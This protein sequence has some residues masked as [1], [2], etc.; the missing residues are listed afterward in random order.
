MSGTARNPEPSSVL[1]SPSAPVV[2]GAVPTLAQVEKAI[3]NIGAVITPFIS[4]IESG[5]FWVALGA[6]KDIPEIKDDIAVLLAYAKS[7]KV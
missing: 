2:A 4:D 7:L 1:A 6:I 3:E 5:N